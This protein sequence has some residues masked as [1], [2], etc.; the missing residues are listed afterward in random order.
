M[1]KGYPIF[2]WIPGIPI[3]D[4]DYKTQNEDN[5]ISSTNED[6]ENDDNTENGEEA[7]SIKEATYKDDYSPDRENY[8]SDNIIKNQ[9]QTDQEYPTIKNDGKENI[10]EYEDMEQTEEV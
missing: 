8:L 6:E 2:E 10:I 4:K 5:D 1:T 7:K 3:T 9:E